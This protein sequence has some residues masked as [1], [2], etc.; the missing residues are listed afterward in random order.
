MKILRVRLDNRR[1]AFQVVTRRATFEFPYALTNP[2]PSP[3]NPVRDVRVDPELGDEGFTYVLAS[4]D[5]GSVHVDHVLAHHEDP[6]YVREQL[7]YRL[8]L[9]AERALAESGMSKRAVARSLR[10]SQ[11]QLARLLDAR[12]HAKSV[13]RML[14]LL[15]VLGRNVRVDVTRRKRAGAA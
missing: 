8:S 13:D 1:H 11:S 12:N 10:T 7:L 4:G 5:E 9:E 14:A 3:D 15:G 6:A 2:K